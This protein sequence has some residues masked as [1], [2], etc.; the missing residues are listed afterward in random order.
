MMDIDPNLVLIEPQI[1]G[2]FVLLTMVLTIIMVKVLMDNQF[3]RGRT[4]NWVR[5]I[6]SACEDTP[7]KQ[8]RA[9]WPQ[10][11]QNMELFLECV[12]CAPPP[13]WTRK[14]RVHFRFFIKAGYCYLF[15]CLYGKPCFAIWGLSA[16]FDLSATCGLPLWLYI[17]LTWL[18]LTLRE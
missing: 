18:Y 13:K 15:I 5:R 8:T 2:R 17:L 11:L 4:K 10:F 14:E 1:H 9:L 6:L 3:A 16:I 12:F 7:R